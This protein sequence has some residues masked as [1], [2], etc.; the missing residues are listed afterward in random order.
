MKNN[1]LRKILNHPEKDEIVSKLA[2][3][4]SSK[5]VNQWLR[6]K[7]AEQKSMVISEKSLDEF[8][9]EFLDCYQQIQNDARALQT[10]TI[11]VAEEA[12]AL[13]Q[14]NSAYRNKLQEYVN[15]EID[16][17][18]IVK[19]MVVGIEARAQQV[20]DQIQED[21]SNFK[22]DYVLINW[23]NALTNVLEKYDAILNGP[24]DKIV[25]QNNINIQ[26]IDQYSSIFQNVIREVL[27]RLDYE[28]SML[29]IDI[30][31]AELTKLKAPTIESLPVDLRL[32]EAK[33][34]ETKFN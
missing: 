2:L 1:P 10:S 23:F 16:I 7:Y 19:N 8:K 15:K 18:T 21:P 3:G 4:L 13:V 26:V 30:L 31:N 24:A 9:E 5:E 14:N 6:D 25:Q 34:L 32:E 12:S 33:K 27:S 22:K 28:T 29:F 11:S 20:F 17:K